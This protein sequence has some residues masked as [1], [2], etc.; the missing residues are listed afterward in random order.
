MLPDGIIEPSADSPIGFTSDVFTGVLFARGRDLWIGR[1]SVLPSKQDQGYF[2]RLLAVLMW[3]GYRVRVAYPSQIMRQI[4]ER[5]GFRMARTSCSRGS[6]PYMELPDPATL[7]TRARGKYNGTRM[8]ALF[9]CKNSKNIFDDMRNNVELKSCQEYAVTNHSNGTRRLGRFQ[10]RKHQHEAL[11]FVDGS[12]RL[13]VQ[14]GQG[15]VLLHRVVKAREIDQHL[16]KMTRDTYQ[17]S[18]R[19]FFPGPPK[20]DG[21]AGSDRTPLEY[22]IDPALMVQGISRECTMEIQDLV[23]ARSIGIHNV[24]NSGQYLRVLVERDAQG[25]YYVTPAPKARDT[26]LFLQESVPA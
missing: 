12:Y 19:A 3:L 13:I 10:F 15:T 26:P 9:A 2:T 1:I 7:S 22:Q 25:T 20:Q 17:R 24:P 16:V 8:E 4:L 21:G 18:W 6:C 11:L 23:R 14:D 5:R